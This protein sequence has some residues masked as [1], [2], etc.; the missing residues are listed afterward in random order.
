MS[1]KKKAEAKPWGGRFAQPTDDL[2]ETFS[3][4][5]HF[6]YKLYPYDIAGS[7]AHAG[8]LGRQ[9]LITTKEAEAIVQGLEEIKADIEAGRFKWDP[10]LED[11]HM[12]IERA[13]A[14]RIGP[15]GEKLHTARS[16]NDQVAL[17]TR[18]YVKDALDL[19]G[20]EIKELRLAL[21]K[22]AQANQDL[23]MPGYTH[24]QRAQPVLPAHHLLAYQEM[25]ARDGQ[26]LTDLY[27]RV[28]IMPLGGAALAG[29]GL[30]ID[31]KFVAESL[32]FSKITANSMDGVSDRD[33]LVE[34]LASA[35]ILMMHL[36]RLSEDLILWSTSE[37]GFVE[38]PDEFCTGSSIMPQKK[39][40]DALELIRGKTGRIFGNLMGMLTVM[41]GL[42]L[43]YNRDLQEDKEPLFDTVETMAQALPLMARLVSRLKFKAERMR[44]AADDPFLTATDLADHLVKQGVPFRQAHAMVGRTVRYCL[45]RGLALSDLSEDELIRLCPGARAG[46]KKELTV[47]ASLDARVSLGGTAP[48]RVKAALKKALR[49]LDPEQ[50]G[51]AGK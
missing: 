20:G 41:K 40:P 15:A 6:D 42:P 23:V 49:E 12:N 25:L 4:S 51:R 14:D 46:V 50:R 8:M 21:V 5:V 48:R 28:D 26:R 18:L 39:N 17:D 13:L 7:V 37:F 38:L 44:A 16:R 30:P 33:Y 22:Q 3:A 31:M 43:A 45:D 32:G 36:S 19:F 1:G 10:G 27:K 11:V 35:S 24:L 29:T 47:E 2:L 34:F 9:G